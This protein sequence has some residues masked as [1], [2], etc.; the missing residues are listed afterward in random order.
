ML[1]ALQRALTL[2]LLSLAVLWGAGWW[3]AGWP[4]LGAAGASLTVGGHALLMAIELAI[5][6]RLNRADPA[7]QA[8]FAQVLRAWWAEARI[9]PTVFCWSQPFRSALHADALEASQ[10][11]RHRGVVLVHGF[12]CNR[13]F[14]NAWMRRLRPLGVPF[15]AVSLEP[16]FGPIEGYADQIDK[17]VRRMTA[18]TGLAPVVVAHSMGGLAVRSWLRSVRRGESTGTC[19]A[20]VHHVVT[21]GTP[22]RGTFLARFGSAPSTAQMRLASAWLSD[23]QAT[24]PAS[25]E[26]RF[27]CFYSHCDNVVFPASTATLPGADNR[28][29]PAAA[30]VDMAFH[31]EVFEAVLERTALDQAAGSKRRSPGSTTPASIVG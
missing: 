17:A 13:G 26:Q 2:G 5:G 19:T 15:I 11:A 18:V 16:V 4:V 9:A 22:H 14:W 7:P 31:D 6:W 8:T 3:W 24:E 27:T 28:H 1:S 29:L 12:L 25:Q 20:R 30:H 21:I 23:L 10:P